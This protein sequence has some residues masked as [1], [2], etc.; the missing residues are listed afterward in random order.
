MWP[1]IALIGMMIAAATAIVL[2]IPD[3]NVQAGRLMVVLTA[4]LSALLA[5]VYV[6]MG[7]E[8]K[9]DQATKDRRE[10]ESTDADTLN[11]D[12]E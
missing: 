6:K 2:F 11:E 5:G 4:G 12:A 3:D 8:K 1:I 9:V 10:D 7:V